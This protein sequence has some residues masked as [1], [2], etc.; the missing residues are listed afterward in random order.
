MRCILLWKSVKQM[1]A[2][3]FSNLKYVIVFFL[4]VVLLTGLFVVSA[5]IPQSAIQKN[6]QTSAEFLCEGELVGAV[7]EGVDGSKIDRY[8]DA[9]LLAIAYQYDEE[10]PLTSVMWSS[11][12]YTNY[13]NENKNLL[14]AV[15]KNLEANQ[16]YLRYWHGSN[17]FLRP[18]L[19]IFSIQ[20]IYIL[21]AIILAL[22]IAWL[23]F[24]L[25]KE[26]AWIPMIGMTVGFVLTSSWFVPLSLEYT[27]TYMLMLSMCIIS[28][29]LVVWNQ[30]EHLGIGFLIIGILTNYMD[31]L[32][33]ETL[34][35]FIPL[36]L[37][38]WISRNR[39]SLSVLKINGHKKEDRQK[40][41]C[42]VKTI[43][44]WIVAWGFGYVGMWLM[45][46][47]IAAI[48][49]QQNVMPYVKE[50]I[51]ERTIGDVGLNL[52][53][54]ITGTL[55][56]NIK[57]LFPFEY[58]DL[59]ILFG[60]ICLLLVFYLGYVYHKKQICKEKIFLYGAIG[61][62]PFVRYLVLLN[63]SY[64]HYF[65]TYR[66]LLTTV[67]AMVMIFGEVVEWRFL[68]GAKKR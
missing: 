5:S 65:F 34:T 11:Y 40:L 60:I 12:Y 48:V 56:R 68:T 64:L 4:M 52:W 46:W 53:Q 3:R 27:W 42:N 45:K 21:N 33:T 50:H 66:A 30:W 16:Q 2:I 49:L 59:G 14:D 63:H 9:I 8:A 67:L 41:E 51:T 17:A 36:L 1:V 28:L 35:L 47:G 55:Y 18:L 25:A 26:R 31:F 24:L 23:F 29:K 58:G 6:V 54:Y 32:T 38:V 62:L 44:T 15:T 61:I 10:N 57:C 43:G 19:L 37:V 13:Q 20:Q 22:L 7:V 39:N